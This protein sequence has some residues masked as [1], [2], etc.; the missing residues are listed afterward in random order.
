MKG[1]N[2]VLNFDAGCKTT[3]MGIMPHKDIARAIELALSLDIPYWPQLPNVSFYE[4]MYAQTS[5]G[6]P[7]VTIDV[8]GQR[9]LFDSA[10]FDRD[11]AT[12]SEKMA[13]TDYYSLSEAYSSVYHRF[14]GLDLRGHAAVRGQV[15]G[16]V[17]FGFRVVDQ[18]QR[19]IIYDESIRTMLFDFIQRKLNAQYCQLREK[20]ENAFVWADEP[21]LGWVFSGLSG[22][23]DVQARRDYRSFLNGVEGMKALHLCANV[24]LPYLLELGVDMVS[25]DAY[26]IGVMPK[27]Y[28]EPVASFLKRDGVI[29]W[30]LVPTDSTS[31]DKETAESLTTLLTGYWAVLSRESGISVEQIARQSLISPARCCLKNI[32]AVGAAG[33]PA[34]ATSA[35]C[36]VASTEEGLVERAFAVLREL[37]LTLKDKFGL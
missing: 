6:F 33:E 31:L 32:G 22:Y 16:P 9:V 21:G 34:S 13:D 27:A 29:A 10:R 20:N 25:F 8:Q 7:G 19:P 5:E 1:S 11:L 35:A 2:C 18:T 26:Q 17:S 12:Y 23:D 37:S 30:G 28:A 36:P 3:A 4:D 15:T 14:L 24:N